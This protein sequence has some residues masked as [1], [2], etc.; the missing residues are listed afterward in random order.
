MNVKM[1]QKSHLS[2]RQGIAISVVMFNTAIRLEYFRNNSA[3][4]PCSSSFIVKSTAMPFKLCS[5]DAKKLQS[6]SNLLNDV[7]C[8][9]CTL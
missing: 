1:T 4:K 5:K 7:V 2:S 3:Y 9:S 8:W 6:G